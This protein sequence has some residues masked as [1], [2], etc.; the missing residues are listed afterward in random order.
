MSNPST[1][2]TPTSNDI[3][4]RYTGPDPHDMTE[5]QAELRESIER[6]RTTGLS[7][8]FGPWLAVPKIALPA[9]ELG[10][11]V[12][13]ETTLT[14]RE[15]EL[16]IL[17]TGAAFKSESEFDI[18]VGEARK[19][20]LSWDVID[21]IPRGRLLSE[22]DATDDND[23]PTRPEFSVENV[24]KLL[25]PKLE[26][27]RDADF[28]NSDVTGS[29]E[30]E[31]AIALFT[32]ELL[33]RNTVSDETYDQTRRILGGQDSVLVEIT[34]IVGYYAYVAYTLNVFKIPTSVMKRDD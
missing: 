10:R 3:Q 21:S 18:H 23:S 22:E 28:E 9:Q 33:E 1:R 25:I 14:F 34:S 5:E 24:R 12:R 2:W 20:G 16:V 13:Y 26:H 29:A 8:P 30:R 6:S 17:L 27:D 15:S 19:A 11:L 32:A 31:V 7:G 4:P